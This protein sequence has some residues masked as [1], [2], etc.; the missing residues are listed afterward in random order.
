MKL[1]KLYSNL[2]KIFNPINFNINEFNEGINVVFAQIFKPEDK[3]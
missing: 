3:E 1:S 2:P